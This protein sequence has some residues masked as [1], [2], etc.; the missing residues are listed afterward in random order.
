MFSSARILFDWILCRNHQISMRIYGRQ[1]YDHRDPPK[2]V[3]NANFGPLPF[4]ILIFLTHTCIQL[5]FMYLVPKFGEIWST[6]DNTA[7]PNSWSLWG[8]SWLFQNNGW[9]YAPPGGS[10]AKINLFQIE[11][12]LCRFYGVKMVSLWPFC[13]VLDFFIPP[14]P[15]LEFPNCDNTYC[16]LK[17]TN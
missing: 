2:F 5:V 3:K 8:F 12:Y 17:A 10:P 4:Q 16:K 6:T 15:N 7:A 11:V 1:K 14:G 9:P 13:L